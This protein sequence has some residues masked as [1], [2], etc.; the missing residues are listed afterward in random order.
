M[1]RIIK[2]SLYLIPLVL[3]SCGSK[4]GIQPELK[5]VK[6]LIFAS[7]VINWDDAYNLTAQTDGIL[8]SVNFDLGDTV[9]QGTVMATIDN[10]SNLINTQSAKQLLGISAQNI[11]ADAPALKQ[12][13]QNI[14]SAEN[15]YNQDK[16]QADRLA[17][18]IKINA[19]SQVEYENGKLAAENS[20][21]QLNALKNQYQSLL[22]QAQQQYINSN[23][24]LK[25]SEVILGYN[26]LIA[27]QGGTVIKQL[28][29]N[30]D[31]VRKGDIIAIISNPNNVEAVLNVDE[32]SIG[33]IKPG[34]NVFIK[35]N[36]AKEKNVTGKISEIIPAFDEKTQS[37][38]CKVKFTDPLEFNL[39]GTQLE[40]NILVGEK[41][42][43]LLI[44]RSYMGY[45][46]KV[47]V[48]GKDKPVIIKPGIISTEYVE[49][50]E[51]IT[52]D[53]IILPLKP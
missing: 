41:K 37:F 44:P 27:P 50:L 2:H 4:K 9:S 21:A 38:I 20:L 29:A 34:Q 28:K 14:L 36:T 51:G 46:N 26:Q 35:L 15:K 22:L 19:V 3:L 16:T 7:G 13:E 25:N 31:Y 47:N 32:N 53:D 30:G 24:Q 39:Y 42:N 43:A 40:A 5:D 48:K 1:K 45:G 10:K 17:S 11:S 49:I 12:L 52:Q 23:N 8:T 18:L 33:K 6:E